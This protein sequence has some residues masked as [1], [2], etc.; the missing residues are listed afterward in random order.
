[1]LRNK[2]E[3]RN[4]TKIILQHHPIFDKH[5]ADAVY[6]VIKS[7]WVSEGPE[8][9]KFQESYRKFIGTKYA[10]ATT[11]GTSAIFLSLLGFDIKSNDEVIVPN[12]TFVA[13][14][15]AVKLAGARPVL[16][17]IDKENFTISISAIKKK[18]TKKT[19]VIIPVHLNGRTTDLDELEEIASKSNI[20]IIEDASQALGSKYKNK[21]LGSCGDVAAFS[22]APTKIITT[23]QGGI[24][25]TNNFTIYDKIMRI[26]DQGRRD[27]SD[28]HPIVGYNFKFTDIQA[29]LGNSQFLKLKSRLY[30]NNKNYRLYS[31]LLSQNESL[32]I[33][34]SQKGT[35]LWYF[36]ILTNKRDELK[37]YL[38]KKL[39]LTKPFH[40][41]ISSHNPF[42]TNEKFLISTN[43]S[44]S[45]LYL[46]SSSDLTDADIESICKKINSSDFD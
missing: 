11:S 4:N 13:T 36:D 32:K 2:I 8:T 25:T 7:G 18:I 30:A 10:I 28:N 5:D 40:K 9:K 46:P 38:Q 6:K 20:K 16:A 23:G 26:K 3:K 34:P 12:I 24:I 41:P 42:K 1:M 35:Q 29:A 14:A 45:G 39:V 43:I 37:E 22:L 44:S 19:K 17:E 31:E 33:P 15:T 27:K 21:F